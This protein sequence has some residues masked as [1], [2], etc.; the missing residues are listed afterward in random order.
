M[1]IPGATAIVTGGG[2]GFGQ[3]IAVMLAAHGAR[4]FVAGRDLGRL[5]K[6]VEAINAQ[7][8]ERAVPLRMD[9]GDPASVAQAFGKLDESA[10]KL[11]ILVNNAG[12]REIKN[13]Y[14]LPPDEWRTVIDTNLN[15]PYYCC[16]EAALRMRKTGGGNI[17]N[18]SSI[19]GMMGL[20]NRPA[21]NASKHGL[22]GLTRNLANDLAPDNIRVNAVAPGTLR[23]PMTDPFYHHESFL[24]GLKF[25]VP[26]GERGESADVAKVVLFLC[27]DLASFVNG[28]VIPVDGGWSCTKSY[29]NGD[30]PSPYNTFSQASTHQD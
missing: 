21:Y 26:M 8:K 27:S 7:G 24:R 23:T 15:G 4:V 2:S 11:D 9:V 6:T 29:A 1:L 17:V 13:I 5:E 20:P 22:I 30:G 28:A 10:P 19:A 12:I 14:D 25:S 16:R 18:I 3:D